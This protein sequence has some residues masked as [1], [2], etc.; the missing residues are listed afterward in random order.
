MN[1]LHKLIG[2]VTGDMC[3]QGTIKNA[4]KKAAKLSTVKE[5]PNS[6]NTEGKTQAKKRKKR[7]KKSKTKKAKAAA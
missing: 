7:A 3:F 4:T 2:I 5:M 1:A 6:S